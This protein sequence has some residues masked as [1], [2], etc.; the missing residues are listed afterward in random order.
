MYVV[1]KPLA[2]RRKRERTAYQAVE[3]ALT[4]WG[5][6]VVHKRGMHEKAL[7]ID[8]EILWEGSLNPL[9]FSDSQEVM[10]RYRSRPIFEDFWGILRVSE[11]L[12]EYDA[13]APQ[14][15]WCGSEV[16]ASEGG[17]QPKTQPFYWRCAREECGYM[18]RIDEP[19]YEDGLV[20]CQNCRASLE[21]GQWGG[22][23][24][25]RC[26][27]NRHHRRAV[28]RTHLMLPKMRELIPKAELCRLDRR[29]GIT[30]DGDRMLSKNGQA[31]L[32]DTSPE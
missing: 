1:T 26:T 29:Y 15:P 4:E 22:K 9:S 23:P 11:L 16:V 25:W 10:Q 19:K 18:R 30:A 2:D 20:R 32:F 17:S 31:W 6:V 3:R 24:A 13:H 21:Y 27:A 8:E 12:A 7:F 28:T 5:A 14:C